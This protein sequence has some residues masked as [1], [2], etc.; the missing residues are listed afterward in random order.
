[1]KRRIAKQV[2]GRAD[3]ERAS[4]RLSEYLE[5]VDA[6]AGASERSQRAC[7]YRNE[8]TQAIRVI[9]A[10]DS[11]LMPTGAERMERSFG[12]GKA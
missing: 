10:V 5:Y 6:A 12:W 8:A 9:R 7:A 3:A 1:M 4:A 11:S 2:F